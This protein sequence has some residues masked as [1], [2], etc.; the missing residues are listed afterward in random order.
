VQTLPYLMVIVVLTL[1]A[2]AMKRSR[3]RGA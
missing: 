1:M 2:V 3:P